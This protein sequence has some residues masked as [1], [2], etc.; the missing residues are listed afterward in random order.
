MPTTIL[1]LVESILY[2][3]LLFPVVHIVLY[4]YDVRKEYKRSVCIVIL[5]TVYVCVIRSLEEDSTETAFA[6]IYHAWLTTQCGTL[7]DGPFQTWGKRNLGGGES[8]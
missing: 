4:C 2:L 8:I 6:R 7:F 1:R 5:Y 3:D